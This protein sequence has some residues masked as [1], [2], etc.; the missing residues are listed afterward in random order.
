MGTRFLMG[1]RG[2]TQ[3]KGNGKQDLHIIVKLISHFNI[4]STRT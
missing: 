1:M 3:I 2:I 4:S